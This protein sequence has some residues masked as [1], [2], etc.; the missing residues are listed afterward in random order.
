M[1]EFYFIDNIAIFV[2]PRRCIPLHADVYG[3]LFD[4][5]ITPEA[6]RGQSVALDADPDGALGVRLRTRDT[7]LSIVFALNTVFYTGACIDAERP[8]VIALDQLFI[9]E[10]DI[11]DCDLCFTCIAEELRKKLAVRQG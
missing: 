2:L 4:L 11:C 6:G 8:C 9:D 7:K 1:I 10:E 5:A 3:L